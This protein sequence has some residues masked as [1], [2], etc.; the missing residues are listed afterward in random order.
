MTTIAGSLLLDTC[1]C[2]WISTG[3]RMRREA[4]EAVEEAVAAGRVWIS[5]FVA[6]EIANL[7]GRGRV[8]D[9][10]DPR[11]WL[12]RLIDL[13]EARLAPLDTDLL[14][15]SQTLPDPVHKDPAD[16]IMIATARR[17]NA[18][19]VTRDAAIEAYAALGHLR[20]LPC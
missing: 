1:A 5:P 10:D 20:V 13:T 15:D 3:V 19:L 18:T 8:N 6:W 7:S 4:S 2:I 11:G 14:I 16:R 12:R 9:V 17:L